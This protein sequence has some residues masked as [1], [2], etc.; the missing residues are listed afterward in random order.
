M[1][2]V[3]PT[4]NDNDH[5]H[6]QSR[7]R[8]RPKLRP[9]DNYDHFRFL[10][11]PAELRNRIYDYATENASSNSPTLRPKS[12]KP[13]KRAVSESTLLSTNEAE[14]ERRVI[15]PYLALTQTC[16]QIRD[17]FRP[18]WLST[19]KIPLCLMVTYLKA[20][21]PGRLPKA[22][23]LEKPVLDTYS[24]RA[25][26]RR[27]DLD[28]HAMY[29]ATRLLKHKARFPKCAITLQSLPYYS[30]STLRK[31]ERLINHDNS[32]WRQALLRGSISQIRL[33]VPHIGP[34][35]ILTDIVMKERFAEPWM[36]PTLKY[37]ADDVLKR[38]M[39]QLGFDLETISWQ[40]RFYVD[41]S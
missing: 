37:Q 14:P 15:I 24:L 31:M 6:E 25:I 21:F 11:L 18:M 27:D 22:M 30:D 38:F 13:I 36:K 26:V 12:K 28:P 3:A 4:N 33:G 9:A 34:E 32:T 8:K 17:E 40:V 39:G 16:R 1:D 19:P 35:I 41:Y 7:S 20:F 23:R 29:D 10:D 5:G 2:R